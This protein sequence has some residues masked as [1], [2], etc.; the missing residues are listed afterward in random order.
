[1]KDVRWPQ[2]SRPRGQPVGQLLVGAQEVICRSG[3]VNTFAGPAVNERRRLGECHIV[4]VRRYS[5][6]Q[7]QV[8]SIK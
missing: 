5:F 2:L 1:M 8:C 4:K 6:I 3:D 7:Q